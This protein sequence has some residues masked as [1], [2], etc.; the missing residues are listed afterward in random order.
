MAQTIFSID[1][2][3]LPGQKRIVWLREEIKTTDEALKN[4]EKT[5]RV[6]IR[7]ITRAAQLSWGIIQGAIRAAGGSIT[8]TTRLVISSAM[9]AIQTLGP[10]LGAALAGGIAT[11]DAKAIAAS[12]VGLVQLGTAITALIAYE[13]GQKQISLQLRGLT[14]MMSNIGMMIKY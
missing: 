10:I 4:L 14:F 2:D 12:M 8:M 11:M 3:I 1:V 5:A 13:T 9:G 6:A 7:N